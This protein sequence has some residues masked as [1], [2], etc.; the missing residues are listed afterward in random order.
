MSANILFPFP[1]LEARAELWRK[2][3]PAEAPVAG[4]IDFLGLARQFEL[5][6]GFI[7][8]VVLRAAFL[9]AREGRPISTSHLERSARGEYGDRG[10]LT[11]GGRLT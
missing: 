6:G 11:A 9:A 3:I 5:S 4:A 8:N 10:A 1:D 7:R 2:M